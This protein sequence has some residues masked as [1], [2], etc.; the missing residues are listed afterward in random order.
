MG[1]GFA[2]V[3]IGAAGALAAGGVPLASTA[4][5]A[6]PTLAPH[7]AVY[8][9]SL[10]RAT[11]GGVVNARGE[12]NYKLENTCAGWTMETRTTLDLTYAEGGEMATQWEFVAYES[13]DG[14]DYSF[15]V[16]NKRNG[17]V[18]E[19]LE[20]SAALAGQPPKGE[21]SFHKPENDVVPLPAGTLFPSAHT[22]DI[23]RAAERGERYLSRTVFDGASEEGP[24]LVTAFIGPPLPAGAEATKG[25]SGP[26]SN[27]AGKALLNTPSWRMTIAFFPPDDREDLPN[28][29]VRVRYH[30]NGVAQEMVQDFGFFS[31]RTL[32]KDIKPLP[33]PDC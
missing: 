13:K 17:E 11:P 10:A 24:S 32:L 19:V 6:G 16:R 20:G 26:V 7:E 25:L 29:E 14:G 4:Q 15:F 2:A 18:D 27:E 12:M 9:L 8:A 21:A 5:A 1:K 28:Y 3:M 30:D 31:L 23:L 22:L 33:E